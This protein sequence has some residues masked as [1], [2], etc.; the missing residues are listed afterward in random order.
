MAGRKKLSGAEFRKR[1][2]VKS[3][4]TANAILNTPKFYFI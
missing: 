2:K 1:A 4:K 3:D